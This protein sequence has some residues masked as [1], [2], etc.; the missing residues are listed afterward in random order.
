[1]FAENKF[2]N[3]TYAAEALHRIID[4]GGHRMD[5]ELFDSLVDKYVEATPPELHQWLRDRIR[6]SNEPSLTKRL[7]QMAAR[8]GSMIMPMIGKRERWAGT[9]AAVR[10]DI[11]HLGS[12]DGGLDGGLLYY[13]TESVFTITQL[14]LLLHLG[15]PEEAL[16]NK[17]SGQTSFR[18]GD[19]IAASIDAARVYLRGNGLL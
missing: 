7:N 3:V 6:Y 5:R 1:M 8:V 2:M 9:I 4:R 13:L 19:R 15:V 17:L 18:Q 16:R 14:Y 12:R 11:T 10:N